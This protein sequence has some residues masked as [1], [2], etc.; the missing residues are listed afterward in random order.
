MPSINRLFITQVNIER[1][2]PSLHNIFLVHE[3]APY[4][5]K[6][7][8]QVGKQFLPLIHI[9]EQGFLKPRAFYSWSR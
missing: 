5:E 4:P 7:R 6:G 8:T 9:G 1:A 2:F 3:A